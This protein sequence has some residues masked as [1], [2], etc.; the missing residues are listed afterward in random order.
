MIFV[1]QI[2]K[3]IGVGWIDLLSAMVFRHRSTYIARGLADSRPG[4]K[5]LL[6][7]YVT[8]HNRTSC[9]ISVMK[10]NLVLYAACATVDPISLLQKCAGKYV[11]S[12]EPSVIRGQ[13]GWIPQSN[14]SIHWVCGQ[15]ALLPR[16]QRLSKQPH[17]SKKRLDGWR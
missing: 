15:S 5:K 17:A 4:I 1:Y 2:S 8:S 9:G 10:T 12:R 16:S 6:P 7:R 14:D 3:V 13:F 11:E